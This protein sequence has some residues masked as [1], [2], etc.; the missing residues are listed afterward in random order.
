ME[1]RLDAL[2]AP[3]RLLDFIA[4]NPFATLTDAADR[5]DIAFTTAQRGVA[6][7]EKLDILAQVGDAK[8]DRVFCARPL[9]DIIEEPPRLTPT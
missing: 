5:L 7:L 4:A 9:L 3:A 8:R 1:D 6:K 2:E